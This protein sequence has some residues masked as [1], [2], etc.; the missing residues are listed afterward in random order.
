MCV[1]GVNLDK[2]IRIRTPNIYGTARL[3]PYKSVMISFCLR[4]KIRGVFILLQFF[5]KRIL[6]DRCVCLW[7]WMLRVECVCS[8]NR[9]ATI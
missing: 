6:C 2:P 4:V 3:A 1:C 9:C 8:W 7:M 5:K